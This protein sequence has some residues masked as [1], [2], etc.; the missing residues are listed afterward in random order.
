MRYT[1]LLLCGALTV[2][3]GC[4]RQLDL[5]PLGTVTSATYYRTAD[6]ARAA[7]TGAYS[8]LFTIYRDE[9]I[10]TPT[11]V[12]A[13]DAV[14]FL[15][16]N[17]DRVALWKYNLVSTNTFI[18]TIWAQS[19]FGIQR[20][21]VVLTRVPGISMDAALRSRYVAEAQF[22]RALHYFNLVRFFGEV[23]L[24]T[25]ET[26][27]LAGTN[28]PRNPTA[29][30]YDLIER[31]LK[32]AEAVLP[33]TYPA[34]DVGRATQGAAKALLAKVYLTRAGTT[35]GSPFWAQAAAKAKEVMDMGQY[36]LWP[37]FADVFAI[38]NSGGRESVFEVK[39][40]TDLL[41]NNFST[42]YAPRGAPIVPN[43]GSGIFRVTKSLFESYSDADRR[44]AA[45]FLTSYQQ[46]T[47]GQRVDLSLDNP[48]PAR[49]VAFWKLHDPSSRIGGQAG[50][51]FPYLRFA[52]VLLM[53]AEALNEANNGPTAEAY[54]SLNCVRARAGLPALSGL[55]KAAFQ[56]AVLLERR[57]E[58]CFEGHR[59]FD[60]ART[61][62]LVAAVRA[63]NSFGRAA[64]VQPFHVVFPIPQRERDT[65]TALTQN[66]GY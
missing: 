25:T 17:A 6:D 15:T 31:D 4:E 66:A 36:D 32:E 43:N 42:G 62:R 27:S 54:T 19:Y 12:G 8:Q 35:S 41:G 20:C 64:E 16:G 24:V 18:G 39:F 60:L 59:W 46:P 61:G 10:V 33:R 21:N 28:V 65:N 49:A 53:H 45:T 57:L 34:A 30:V 55:T 51:S 47:T 58:L 37:N 50:K 56:E 11:T 48:D 7:V 29:E 26:T 63:E 23:P 38:A 9:V 3:A 44:K 2:L 5:A 14:P 40:V 1:L 13:D 22:L 52:D